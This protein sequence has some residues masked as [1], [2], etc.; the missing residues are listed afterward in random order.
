MHELCLM[1]ETLAI[2]LA[3]ATQQ[4]VHQ[5]RLIRMR[6]GPLSGVVPEALQFAFDV[7]SQGTLAEGAE[8]VIDTVPIRCYCATCELIF[9]PLNTWLYECPQCHSYTP[10]VRQGTELE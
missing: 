8:F 9:E 2:A 3:Y 5:I 4:Q 1:E 6:V 10:E 7:V